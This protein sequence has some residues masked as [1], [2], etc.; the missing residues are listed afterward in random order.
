MAQCKG[1][2]NI[3]QRI[4]EI[5]AKPARPVTVLQFGEGNF[6]RAFA[7]WMIDI[8][9]EKGVMNAGIL[10]AKP[11]AFGSLERLAAQD[12]VYTVLLRG[13]EAGQARTQT[14]IVTSVAG[15]VD[16]YTQYAAYAAQ[17]Q[18]P[19]LRVIISNT[20]EAGIVYDETDRLEL[21]PPNTYPG[22]LT[23]FLYERWQSFGG[24]YTKGLIILPV[25]LI[26][27]NGQKLRDCC[28]KLTA[29]WKLPEEFA[30]WLR[31]ANVFCQTLVDRIVTGYPR[32]EAG[33]LA[34]QLGYSDDLMVTGE[35]FAL[36]VI[37]SNQIEA[38][39]A[40]F[41]LDKA[42]LPVV[43]TDDLQ[44]YR[45]RKVRLLNGAHTATVPAAYLAGLDTV[46]ELMADPLLRGL[47]ERNLYGELA[48]NVP[49]PAGEVKAFADAVVERFEN[50]FV[51]HS[52]LSITLNSVSK[53]RARVLPTVHDELARTGRL[54]QSLVFSLAALLAFYAPAGAS[55]AGGKLTGKRGGD[56]YEMMDD[57]PV[58]AFFGEF[59]KLPA[60]ELAQ[61][62]LARVDFW[63]EDLRDVA[64]LA[65][66]V[67]GYLHTIREGGMRPAIEALLREAI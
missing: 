63:G 44:P 36:W 65:D 10:L 43:F 41:P 7:D 28:E 47:I 11:I 55:S 48:P 21:A 15:A 60:A 51:R 57:A 66:A 6:L 29:L 25:E 39:R 5:T 38:V 67:A 3:M 42:G 24:D 8:A 23:K 35:P 45:E 56:V 12:C 22:K 46:G 9:N 33:A 19:A 18:N 30:A 4:N 2:E 32:E 20:T 34:E 58:L 50:P 62:C 31:K 59:G 54:P 37:E 1:K 26:E 17:A 64:G 61:K 53:W 49:L 13:K 40:A 52:L 14:R 16:C 27:R